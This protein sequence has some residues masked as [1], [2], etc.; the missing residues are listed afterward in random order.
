MFVGKGVVEVVLDAV[1]FLEAVAFGAKVL[2]L[3]LPTS[4]V[5][6]PEVVV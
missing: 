5:T 4:K 6:V 3:W 1:L 2:V